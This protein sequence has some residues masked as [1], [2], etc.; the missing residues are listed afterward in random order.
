MNSVHLKE[1]SQPTEN[2]RGGCAFLNG[3]S[4]LDLELRAVRGRGDTS[5]FFSLPLDFVLCPLSFFCESSLLP[6]SPGSSSW[7]SLEKASEEARS[8]WHTYLPLPSKSKKERDHVCV[9]PKL[10][11]HHPSPLPPW[12]KL[13]L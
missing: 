2:N 11:I 1:T 9:E 8:G 7:W 5:Q 6:S 3:S 13:H 10:F 4:D 12:I